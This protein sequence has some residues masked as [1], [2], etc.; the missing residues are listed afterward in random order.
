MKIINFIQINDIDIKSFLKIV[1]AIQLA[2]LGI[3]GLDAIGADIP[4]LRQIIGFIYLTFI[5]GIII[6]RVLKIHKLTIIETFLYSVG[7]SLAF[8]MFGGLFINM[9]YPFLGIYRPISTLPLV[10]TIGIGLLVLCILSYKCDKDFSQPTYADLG[11]ITSKSGLFLLLIPLLSIFGT[12]LVNCYKDSTLLLFL[13]IVISLIVCVIGFTKY[14]PTKLYPLVIFSIAISLL[15]HKS[16]ISPYVIGWDVHQELYFLETV[17]IA[18][19]WDPTIYSNLNTMLSITILPAIYSHVLGMNGTWI[20]KII[21]PLILSFVPVGLYHIYQKQTNQQVAFFS[22]FFFISPLIF[23]SEMPSL[24]RQE[25][26]E[27]FY[28]LIILLLL[29]KKIRLTE[30][31][32]LFI[33]FGAGMI[34]SHY[35]VSYIFMFSSFFAFG[36][37]YLM[38]HDNRVFTRGSILIFTTLIL[39]WYIYT[40]GSSPFVSMVHIGDHIYTSIF[41]NFFRPETRQAVSILMTKEVSPLHEITK[42]LYLITQFFITVGIGWLLLKREKIKFCNEYISFSIVNFAMM[43]GCAIIPWFS[44]TLN[45]TRMYQIS[46]I[47]LAPF[48]IIGGNII[49]RSILKIFKNSSQ[50]NFNKTT[51]NQMSF[52]ILSLFLVMFLLFNTGFVYEIAK[53]YP[54]AVSL[55]RANIEKYGDVEDRIILYGTYFSETSVIGAKWLC[56]NRNRDRRV[57]GDYRDRSLVLTSYG[58]MRMGS[59]YQLFSNIILKK[60]YIY[61]GYTN[62]VEGIIV[63][64][65]NNYYNTTEISPPLEKMNKIY[66]N[67]G[68]EV[69][70]YE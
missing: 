35:G 13:I 50:T 3:L 59:T 47:F 15:Y 44:G 49:V 43:I 31:R 25:I 46:L 57:Y 28:V 17:A 69:Y 2:I 62:V 12:Y 64:R 37:L 6:L 1:L 19:R 14:I 20:I 27:L 41:T 10:I 38:K 5:P 29:D 70:Y 65:G 42:Y 51:S 21:Y 52:K 4:I 11:Q 34:V 40:A 18:S 30:I 53:D 67:G 61:L 24:A 45:T 54:G 33:I 7:L 36:I 56:E 22:T 32:F 63:D 39:S 16:L 66:S 8:L 23:W 60:V 58:R 9:F 68:S 48:C 55:S 26:A